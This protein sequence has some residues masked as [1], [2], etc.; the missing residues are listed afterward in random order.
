METAAAGGRERLI[1][2]LVALVRQGYELP[3]P[4]Y[5]HLRVLTAD[6][7]AWQSPRDVQTGL[8]VVRLL[9]LGAS[10]DELQEL[11]TY[12][13]AHGVG[14]AVAVLDERDGWTLVEGVEDTQPVRSM[15]DLGPEIWIEV[16]EP[17]DSE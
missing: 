9:G 15:G 2:R 10:T 12:G 14:D 5:E 6:S 4:V 1:A 16:N 17:E 3:R 11:V 7:E 8:A 13:Y